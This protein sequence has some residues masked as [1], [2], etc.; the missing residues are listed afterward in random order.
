MGAFF[1]MDIDRFKAIN[2]TWGHAVGDVVLRAVADRLADSV[3]GDDLLMRWGGEEFLVFVPDIDSHRSRRLRAPPAAR[4]PRRTRH[5]RRTVDRDLGV[6]RL[7]AVADALRRRAAGL[8]A[9]GP[10]G[11]PGALPVQGRR[12]QPRAWRVRSAGLDVGGAGRDGAGSR[13]GGEGWPGRPVRASAAMRRRCIL[14]PWKRR[15]PCLCIR[16]SVKKM[17][18][19]SSGPFNGNSSGILVRLLLRYRETRRRRAYWSC[20]ADSANLPKRS[21]AII[22]CRQ[23]AVN[24]RLRTCPSQGEENICPTLSTIP[25][26]S[27]RS[28]L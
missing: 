3:R 13:T 15:L 18:H 12:T 22:D 20:H 2:D 4:G 17:A 14:L 23:V 26:L 11:R 5:R 7:R 16:N 6:G 8:G 25:G 9:P 1:L 27:K 10:P 24:P 19:R 21:R 28:L